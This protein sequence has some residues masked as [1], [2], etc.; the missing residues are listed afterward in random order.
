[1]KVQLTLIFTG[2]FSLAEGKSPE[3]NPKSFDE[4]VHSKN[5]FIKFYAPWCGHC[6]AL[7][8]DWDQLADMYASSPSVVI[9]SVDCTTDDNDELCHQYGVQ[10]YPTLKYFVDGNTLGED[11]QGARSLE[12]LEQFANDTLNK[13]CIVGAEEDMAKV[14]SMCSDKEKE[15]AKKMRG[16]TAD[17]RMTQIE[18]LEKLKNSKMKP[19]L[20]VW[21]FQRLHVLKGL[22]QAENKD[23]L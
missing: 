2:I 18:R 14:T 21:L 12:A 22:T 10:G 3:L 23:E 19:E 11:Y 17:E 7:A 4:L 13:K 15:Y 16:K 5:A 6:K 1:M 20:R 8:P 9:A